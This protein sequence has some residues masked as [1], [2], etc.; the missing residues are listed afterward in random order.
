MHPLCRLNTCR[1]F[2]AVGDIYWACT[3]WTLII[4]R[5]HV[6]LPATCAHIY[7]VLTYMHIYISFELGECRTWGRLAAHSAR[8]PR[9]RACAGPGSLTPPG[10]LEE[11]Q[12]AAGSRSH[13]PIREREGSRMKAELGLT[14]RLTLQIT[15]YVDRMGAWGECHNLPHKLLNT[16]FSLKCLD[17]NTH[18]HCSA[19]YNHSGA[20][21]D[22]RCPW[23]GRGCFKSAVPLQRLAAVLHMNLEFGKIIAAGITSKFL[24]VG[25]HFHSNR[26]LL[27]FPAW[28]ARYTV[29]NCVF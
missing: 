24:F 2:S 5:W 27:V 1:V 17:I 29:L 18:Y 26:N 11:P 28:A 15:G 16:H 10:A 22:S 8:R 19:S 21:T 20:T 6:D 7:F 12:R 4:T 23:A 13:N 3:L 25:I 14:D 9:P